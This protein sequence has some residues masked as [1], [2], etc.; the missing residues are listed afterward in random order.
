VTSDK[1]YAVEQRLDTLRGVGGALAF[2]PWTQF[3]PLSNSW[4][5]QAPFTKAWIRYAPGN[6]IQFSF[7]M[8][9]G[10]TTDGTVVGT[11]Q[12]ADALGNGLRPAQ[13]I[14]FPVSTDRLRIPATGTN[15]E[16]PRFHYVASGDIT[17]FGIA[18]SATSVGVAIMLPLDA[19]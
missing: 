5:V 9:P 1:A 16:G 15:Q 7:L 8:T 6:C 13:E 17:C 18:A 4:A 3:N 2:G 14:D 10:T 12:A 11:V 19:M